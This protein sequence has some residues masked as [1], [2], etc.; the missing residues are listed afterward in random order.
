VA[1]CLVCA[2]EDRCGCYLEGPTKWRQTGLFTSSDW[3][4]AHCPSQMSAPGLFNLAPRAASGTVTIRT[5]SV[6]RTRNRDTEW[7]GTT[8][9]PVTNAQVYTR[10]HR[11]T[12]MRPRC[13]CLF[14]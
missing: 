2:S 12:P 13:Q 8:K 4:R 7:Q 5:P 6:L 3:G 14:T 1:R 11:G 9:Y 10:L